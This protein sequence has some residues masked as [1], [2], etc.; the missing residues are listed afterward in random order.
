MLW[1][2]IKKKCIDKDGLLVFSYLYF[3]D[4]Y[5]IKPW[6][7]INYSLPP[8]LSLQMVHSDEVPQQCT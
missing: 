1:R 7:I 3:M 6:T 2:N 5:L 8:P 4:K